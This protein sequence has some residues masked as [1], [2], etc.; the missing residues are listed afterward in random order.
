MSIET[1]ALK[2]VL[3]GSLLMLFVIISF[4]RSLKPVILVPPMFGSH[5]YADV[6]NFASH[7]YC[8]K[9][10]KEKL[11]W[12]NEEFLIP[13]LT[14]CLGEYLISVFDEEKGVVTNRTGIEI[15]TINWGDVEEVRYVDGGVLGY[16]FVAELSNL[17]DKFTAEGYQNQVN[18]FAAPYDWR[19]AP[20]VI[21]S[22][23]VKLKQLIEDASKNNNDQ[24]VV[25]FSYSAGGMVLHYFCTR[26]VDQEWKDKFIDRV[27]FASPSIGGSM[28]AARVVWDQNIEYLPS[29]YV[30]EST[31]KAIT[32]QPTLFG[33]LPNVHV[34]GDRKI[35]VDADGKEYKA[36]E[37]GKFY[38]EHGKLADYN[39]KIFEATKNVFEDP[40]MDPGVNAYF[41]FNTALQTVD[42]ISFENG[43]E[44]PYTQHFVAGDT[45]MS[46]FAL[47]WGCN[48]WKSADK[49][50]L[51]CHDFNISDEGFTH[52]GML[53]YE[54]FVDV[55]WQ[56]CTTD[57]WIRVGRHNVTGTN[58][59]GWRNIH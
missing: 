10:Y 45:T 20:N 29:F 57:N 52:V 18:L 35:V 58:T 36:S 14:N 22:Y 33:H 44:K 1:I 9:N 25:L 41:I 38:T 42:Y 24:K 4:I 32:S 50:A 46:D 3:V 19:T 34:Y 6:T 55:A 39:A 47:Y 11:L 27:V 54:E 12:V 43:Y 23:Y 40:L 13:P 28:D 53:S 31:R 49:K 21:D 15:Y 17:I 56:V 26:I 30:S 7:W 37:V 51:V 16:H 48:N 59:E 8:P 2:I 5:L